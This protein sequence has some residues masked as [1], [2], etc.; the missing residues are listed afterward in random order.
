MQKVL[1]TT[2][3][4]AG[5][6]SGDVIEIAVDGVADTS[7]GDFYGSLFIDT[8]SG[9]LT[10]DITLPAVQ[11]PSGAYPGTVSFDGLYEG[12]ATSGETSQGS[13]TGEQYVGD[14]V[15]TFPFL[16]GFGLDFDVVFGNGLGI[17]D[18]GLGVTYLSGSSPFGP[19]E[20]TLSFN[21]SV[22]PAPGAIAL[23]G[24][25]GLGRRRRS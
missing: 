18:S 21:Y 15:M 11:T 6:A 3:L 14:A 24:L 4:A 25:A 23:L 16:G 13:V 10:G 17:G 12:I 22:V 20:A 7:Y 5:F 8:G 19:L 9:A 2:L 1:C